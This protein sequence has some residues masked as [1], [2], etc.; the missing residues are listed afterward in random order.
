M[1]AI[2]SDLSR[3]AFAEELLAQNIVAARAALDA[4]RSDVRMARGKKAKIEARRAVRVASMAL[5]RAESALATERT[6]EKLSPAV[7][8]QASVQP[9]A[10]VMET[11]EDGSEIQVRRDIVLRETRV[12]IGPNKRP[13]LQPALERMKVRNL[14]TPRC[15]RAGR[16]YREAWEQAGRDAYP[17]SQIGD[18]GSIGGDPT[19]GNRRIENA[20]G[21]SVALSGA[22]RAIG[23]FGTAMLEYIII[24]GMTISAWAEKQAKSEHVAKGILEM[25]LERLAEHWDTLDASDATRNAADAARC[26][27]RSLHGSI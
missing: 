24:E 19:G 25:V 7:Q 11:R 8:R 16:R 1:N 17:V 21:S 23:V 22:R 15:Y 26:Q 5:G 6:G 12:S 2:T 20:V 3:H 9:D 4:A 27:I 18:S 13:E 14:I 10:L